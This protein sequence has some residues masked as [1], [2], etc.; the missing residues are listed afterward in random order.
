MADLHLVLSALNLSTLDAGIL[1]MVQRVRLT[2]K[3][4]G[5]PPHQNASIQGR[6]IQCGKDQMQVSHVE[7]NMVEQ[8]STVPNS[9][10]YKEYLNHTL[11]L[12][13]LIKLR[14]Q[15]E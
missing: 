14:D 4:H 8:S 11:G 7:K 6:Q 9:L 13:L 15:V 5:P 2:L 12:T 3:S 1:P 10:V